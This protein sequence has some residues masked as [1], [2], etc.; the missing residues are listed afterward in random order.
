M[1]S[2]SCALVTGASSGLG[3][4]FALQIA[5]RV[6]K[7]VLVA[8]REPL[9]E[10]L[11]ERVRAQFPHVAVAVFSGGSEPPSE[12]EELLESLAEIGFTPGSAGEQRRAGRLRG[13][14][15]GG[16]GETGGDAARECRG[17]DPSHPCA[18]AGHDPAR[19]GGD[20]QCELAR[21]CDSDSRF[22]GVCGDQGLRHEFL[23][24]AADRT[25]RTRH[26]GARGVPGSGAHR[27]R[28]RRPA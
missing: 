22:R 5:P 12:R 7:L 3:E 21:Q 10:V 28:K 18:P 17:A 25:A 8:R 6:G 16:L 27:V 23:G 24:S 2:F 4:E 13:I 14:R 20:H 9:L 19:R 26:P 11:A 15:L 1:M